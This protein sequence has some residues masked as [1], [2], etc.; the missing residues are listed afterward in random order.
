MGM[1]ASQARYLQ[2]SARMSNCEY[3]GQQINQQRT[4]LANESAN[5]FNQMLVMQVP[6]VPSSTDFTTVQYTFSDGTN[7]Q[8]LENYYQLGTPDSDYNYVV[9]HSYSVKRYTGSMKKLT[10]P[11]VQFTDVSKIVVPDAYD[12]YQ[13]AIYKSYADYE[14]KLKEYENKKADA[15]IQYKNVTVAQYGLQKCLTPTSQKKVEFDPLTSIYKI[16]DDK[17]ASYELTPIDYKNIDASQEPGK[18]TKAEL[19]AI[20]KSGALKEE[21]KYFS[22]QNADGSTCYLSAVA[23]ENYYNKATSNLM[24][25]SIN[26]SAAATQDAIAEYDKQL[27]DYNT[28]VSEAEDYYNTEVT[29]AYNSYKTLLES[30]RVSKP[31][32]IGNCALTEIPVGQM[33]ESQLTELQQVIYDLAQA[34]ETSNLPACFDANGNY[35]GGVYSFN[36]YGTTYYTTYDDLYLSYNSVDHDEDSNNGI[37]RQLALS[38]YSAAYVDTNVSTTEKAL[39]ETDSSGRFVSIRLENDTVKYSLNAETVTD[40][41]AYEDAMNEYYFKT[42]EYQKTVSDINAKTSIIQQEDRT[43]E[44]RLEQLDTERNT[45]TTEIEAVQKVLSDNIERTYK[46][47][48]D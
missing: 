9:T 7:N 29:T 20:I 14:E 21:D 43:L 35:K 38:Y 30:D 4:I 39:L 22:Y 32:Y 13:E 10:D 28:L 19:D 24:S 18:T 16:T 25:Y 44:L 40:D 37:D 48:G 5:L 11:Q 27:G 23:V 34:G 46:T 36:M 8:V 17:D 3:E 26:L 42:A 45:L 15:Q 31:T 2:L 12:A 1:A 47:F 41:A 6:T 33:T